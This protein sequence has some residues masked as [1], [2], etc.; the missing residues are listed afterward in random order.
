VRVTAHNTY[1]NTPPREITFTT[2]E[3]GATTYLELLDKEQ[4]EI[5]FVEHEGSYCKAVYGAHERAITEQSM[6]G[7]TSS[8][9]QV[10]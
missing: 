7:F 6:R 5:R 1:R 3:M 9:A 2:H 10:D 4:L 8:I